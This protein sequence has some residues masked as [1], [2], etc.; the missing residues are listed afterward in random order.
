MRLGAN[1]MPMA[2]KKTETLQEILEVNPNAKT[3]K[4][5]KTDYE[6]TSQELTKDELDEEL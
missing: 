2:E 3:K 1:G 5:K 6:W 4:E